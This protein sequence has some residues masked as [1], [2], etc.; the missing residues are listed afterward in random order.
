MA[1]KAGTPLAG[2]DGGSSEAV[3][4][5]AE[6]WITTAEEL[7]S[8]A[9]QTGG[10]AGLA[11]YLGLPEAE[12]E[13]LVEQAVAALPDDTPF[14]FDPEDVMEVGLGALDEESGAPPEDELLAFGAEPLPEQVDL[15]NRMPPVRNQEL[16]PTC[17][18]HACAAVRTFLL[19]ESSASGDFSEQYL[20]WD[21]KQRDG[22][23]LTKGTWIHVAMAA[24]EQDGVCLEKTWPYNPIPKLGDEGQGPPPEGAHEEAAKYRILSW[25]AVEPKWVDSLREVLAAGAPVAFGVPVYRYWVS[26]LVR[27][28]GDIRMPLPVD[29]L[30]GGHAMC[31]VGYQD[32]A[33]VPGGGYF[34]VRNSWGAVWATESAVEPGYCRL[35]YE[36]MRTSGRSAGT[37]SVAAAGS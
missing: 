37:A 14:S 33:D 23:P 21:C 27:T 17:V 30:L 4:R 24:L 36:Y 29:E 34:L 13:A 32:D 20:Y 10:I 18:A 15:R 6:L 12:A 5:L 25:S 1:E 8:I 11:A 31:M 26:Q 16:R 9:R 19:G 7:I 35:P 2:I 28:T 22:A 3:A